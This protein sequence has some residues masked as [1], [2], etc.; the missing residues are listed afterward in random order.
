M[1][2]LPL[3]S[4][5]ITEK[6]KMEDEIVDSP[7]GNPSSSEPPGSNHE[8]DPSYTPVSISD[9]IKIPITFFYH[10]NQP[11]KKESS[12]SPNTKSHKRGRSNLS[13]TQTNANHLQELLP[14]KK[15]DRS[16]PKQCKRQN[17]QTRLTRGRTPTR[18]KAVRTIR[19]RSL[20]N[21][22]RLLEMEPR[23]NVSQSQK[24]SF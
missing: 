21:G 1:S 9:S 13:V 18:R 10:A 5:V 19:Q 17:Q 16:V 4:V 3:P 11:Q 14:G 23:K 24:L 8:E 22:N 6:E 15:A 7:E 2:F 12:R 20:V